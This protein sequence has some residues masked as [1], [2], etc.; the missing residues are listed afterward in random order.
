MFKNLAFAK[1]TLHFYTKNETFY[2]LKSYQDFFIDIID[3]FDY[4]D[5]FYI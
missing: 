5:D 4:I 2:K 3:I 1:T